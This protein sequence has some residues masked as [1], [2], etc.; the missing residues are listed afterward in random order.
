LE[1]KILWILI[2]FYI[3]PRGNQNRQ[4]RVI[5]IDVIVSYIYLQGNHN[6]EIKV[7][8]GELIFSYINPQGNIIGFTP[9]NPLF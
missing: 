5:A 9:A 8:D 4:I 1:L 2:L 6:E 3:N 7:T